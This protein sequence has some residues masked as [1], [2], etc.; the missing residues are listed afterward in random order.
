[1]GHGTLFNLGVDYAIGE[2]LFFM[3]GGGESHQRCCRDGYTTDI[4]KVMYNKEHVRECYNALLGSTNAYARTG[5]SFSKAEEEALSKGAQ[6]V[7]RPVGSG[8]KAFTRQELLAE[9][10]A[11]SVLRPS[12]LCVWRKVHSF[13]E[14]HKATRLTSI[15]VV[16]FIGAVIQGFPE[17]SVW[18]DNIVELGNA[19]IASLGVGTDGSLA[20]LQPSLP[21]CAKA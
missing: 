6:F 3:D 19:Y 14:V 16:R 15:C 20:F 1:V 4:L 9:Q 18:D 7:E 10:A 5:F 11:E 12:N 13:I 17:S 21:Q 2:M 8:G